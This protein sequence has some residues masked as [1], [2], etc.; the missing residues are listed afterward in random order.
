MGVMLSSGR[1]PASRSFS[2]TDA[3]LYRSLSCVAIE[4]LRQR[5]YGLAQHDTVLVTGYSVARQPLFVILVRGSTCGRCATTGRTP[6]TGRVLRIF[7]R[8]TG[9]RAQDPDAGRGD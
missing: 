6:D 9:C 7:S 2:I 3:V 8:E 1:M 4:M 5:P